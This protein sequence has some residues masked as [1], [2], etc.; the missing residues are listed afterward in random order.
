MPLTYTRFIFPKT[1]KL[2]DMTLCQFW[3]FLSHTTGVM[4][5]RHCIIP[6]QIPLHS[7]INAYKTES[8]H[9]KIFCKT[10]LSKHISVEAKIY[11]LRL[12]PCMLLY[13]YTTLLIYD[14]ISILASTSAHM[15]RSALK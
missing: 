5:R 7:V 15:S 1:R 11:M 13:V 2:F 4:R 10:H 12:V 3:T 8:K 6:L 9:K 14:H